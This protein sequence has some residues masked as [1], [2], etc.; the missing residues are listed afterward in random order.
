M[1]VTAE[2][3][4]KLRE[5]TGEGLM[6]CKAALVAHGGDFKGAL[7]HLQCQGQAVVRKGANARQ[8]CGCP[9]RQ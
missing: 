4:R 3:V 1:N 7:E 6:S 5:R 2:S 9:V 8:P